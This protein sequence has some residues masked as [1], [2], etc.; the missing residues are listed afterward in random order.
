[1][2]YT[3]ADLARARQWQRETVAQLADELLDLQA[4]H[5]AAH[6][7][8]E[9]QRTR[10]AEA[11]AAEQERWIAAARSHA[12][13]QQLEVLDGTGLLQR[14]AGATGTTETE[15]GAPQSVGQYM[16]RAGWRVGSY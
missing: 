11:E 4:I 5:A 2:S 14:W 7:T 12:E 10:L 6:E 13:K 15:A 8:T 16:A 1:M 3:D 9:R